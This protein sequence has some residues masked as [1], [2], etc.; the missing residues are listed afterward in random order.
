MTGEQDKSAVWGAYFENYLRRADALDIHPLELLDQEWADGATT[1]NTCLLPHLTSD[2][3]V[4]EIGCGIGRVSRFAAA[5]CKKLVC[6]DIIDE[7]LVEAKRNLRE[8][9]NVEFEKINGY[10]LAGFPDNSFDCAYSFTTF[11]HFDFE[12]VINYFAEVHRVLKSAGLAVL[13]FKQWKGEAD[14][15]MLLDKIESQGGI[16][17]YETDLDKWRYVSL[18]LLSTLCAYFGF[19]IEDD[20]LTRFTVRKLDSAGTWTRSRF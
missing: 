5:C 3:I 12:L 10:D 9:Q 18:D 14:L 7:A 17:K 8:F 1:F 6:T 4:L 19:R 16:R 20:D 15:V 2:S 13:E 11:F